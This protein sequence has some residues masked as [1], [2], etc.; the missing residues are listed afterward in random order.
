MS[1]EN[2][3][4]STSFEY[5]QSYQAQMLDYYYQS[6]EKN[7]NNTEYVRVELAKNLINKWVLPRFS[8]KKPSELT[9]VD[10]G[11]S[12][13]LFA[14][15]FSKMGYNAYGVDFDQAA[16][17]L[18][19]KLNLDDGGSAHFF[20][21]DVSDWNLVNPIDIAL[22][23]DIFEHLHDD[24]LGAMLFGIKKKLSPNGCI[25]FHTLPLQY[26]YLFWNQSKM[27]IEFPFILSLFKNRSPQKFSR[28]AIFYSMIL[29]ILYFIR[30][31]AIHKELIKKDGH[32]NPLT[33]ERLE[34]IFSRCGYKLI[35]LESGFLGDSQFDKKQRDYFYKQ[36]ITHRS[37]RGIAIPDNK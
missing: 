2:A 25:V 36:S 21:M 8:P 13:G 37:L 12:V 22:C 24:E 18:A 30:F 7:D 20:K 6:K 4:K 26:D 10:I 17:D 3:P 14:I 1:A 29:D 28:L 27:K 34:D 5:G 35:F 33:Q 23:F 31:G 32:C 19:K 16:I 15:E 9:L 11:C